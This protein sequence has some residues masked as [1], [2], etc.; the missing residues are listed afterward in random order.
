M[1]KSIPVAVCK[2]ELPDLM[3]FEAAGPCLRR[4]MTAA[5]QPISTLFSFGSYWIS[6]YKNR[7]FNFFPLSVHAVR[8][9]P[10]VHFQSVLGR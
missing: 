10:H 9:N 5:S 7:L 6:A 4:R 2:E 8:S 3:M 1:A